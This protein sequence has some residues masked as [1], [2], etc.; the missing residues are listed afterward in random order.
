MQSYICDCPSD[1][2]QLP[3]HKSASGIL[4]GPCIL[5]GSYTVSNY[6][7]SAPSGTKDFGSHWIQGSGDEFPVCRGSLMKVV[8]AVSFVLQEPFLIQLLSVFYI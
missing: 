2:P 5:D 7:C 8:P 3:P 1:C 6:Y 4:I